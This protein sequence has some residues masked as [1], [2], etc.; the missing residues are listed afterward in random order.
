MTDAGISAEW[1]EFF[2]IIKGYPELAERMLILPGNHDVNIVDRANPA[3]L[4]LP[5]SP[6]KTLRKMRTLSAIAAVQGERV[7]SPVAEGALDSTLS[8]TL[9]SKR[10][11]IETFADSGGFGAAAKL[12]ELWDETFPLILPPEEPDGL[13]VAVLD[14]NADTNFSF[15]NALGM[16]S[17]E[18][19]NRLTAAFN[20]YPKARWLIAMH[21][22]PIEYPRPVAAFSVRVGTALVNGSW[23]L[24]VLKPYAARLVVMHGHRH[25]DWIGA[26]GALKIISAPS[27]VM[28]GPTA[29]HYFYIHSLSGG[30]NG[31]V[32]LLQPERVDL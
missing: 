8:A 24:R 3:R 20:A 32:S 17:L 29:P 28:G 11:A 15:T 26:C 30:P 9:A 21:H 14:T 19:A 23:F 27:P 12:S 5:F 25:V 1:A 18:E 22:H 4:D 13:A 10:R 31:S 6:S 7:L 16:I 2:D